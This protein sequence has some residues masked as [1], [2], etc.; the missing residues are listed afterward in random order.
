MTQKQIDDINR[1]VELHIERD[2]TDKSV[3]NF[4]AM[5]A[6]RLILGRPSTYPALG[7]RTAFKYELSKRGFQRVD[8]LK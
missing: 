7:N 2:P 4:D 6:I 5:H 8:L 1:V 3:D